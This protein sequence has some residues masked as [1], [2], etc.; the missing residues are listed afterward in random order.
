LG[1]SG[2]AG[3]RWGV[4]SSG[5]IDRGTRNREVNS[6]EERERNVVKKVWDLEMYRMH[7]F[8]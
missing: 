8:I 6:W 5:M 7:I 1:G 3:M 4:G 2:L